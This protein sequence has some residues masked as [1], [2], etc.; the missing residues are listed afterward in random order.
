MK[1]N[2]PQNPMNLTFFPSGNVYSCCIAS[3]LTYLGNIKKNNLKTIISKFKETLPGYVFENKQDCQY[4]RNLLPNYVN[5]KCLICKEQ[6]FYQID[7]TNEEF[8]GKIFLPLKI[9]EMNADK[10]ITSFMRDPSHEF[11]ISIEIK[12]EELNLETGKKIK[13]FFERLKKNNVRFTVSRPLP[14]CIFN[15]NDYNKIAEEFDVP[16]NCFECHELFVAENNKFRLCPNVYN[17]E[18]SNFKEIDTR[19]QINKIFEDFKKNVKRIEKCKKCVYFSRKWCDGLEF[20]E[21]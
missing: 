1:V 21:G 20:K 2:I 18:I 19:N 13:S 9:K 4:F 14:R 6:P 10:V 12:P 16:R 3:K 7:E 17:F 8:V 11:L 15:G 5:D